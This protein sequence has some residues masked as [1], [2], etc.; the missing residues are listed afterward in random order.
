MGSMNAYAKYNQPKFKEIVQIVLMLLG[1]KKAEINLPRSNA[2]NHRRCITADG[3]TQMMEE[4]ENYELRR[5][6]S[7]AVEE[8][9]KIN[10]LLE[11]RKS[12]VSQLRR[13]TERQW[14]SI[15]PG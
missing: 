12:V 14:A 15:T 8:E 3:L 6:S 7:E 1:K 4:L 10:K 11:R 13:S 9:Y 5:E 2:L